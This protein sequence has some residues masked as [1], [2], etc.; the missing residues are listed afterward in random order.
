[1]GILD[2]YITLIRVDTRVTVSGLNDINQSLDTLIQTLKKLELQSNDT[3]ESLSDK[4]KSY[5]DVA[6][7][8]M[9]FVLEHS[10]MMQEK[11][12]AAHSLGIDIGQYDALSRAF[13]AAGS[14]AKSF[15]ASMMALKESLKETQE[16]GQSGKADAFKAFGVSPTD[17]K[18][19]TK[20]ADQMMVELAGAAAKMDPLQA[21]AGLKQLGISDDAT[22]A[23]LMKG[24]AE[25]ERQIALQKS[26]GVMSLQDADTLN[27]F[28][29]AQ[30]DL[31]AILTRFSDELVIGITPAMTVL[32]DTTIEL[33]AWGREHE[34]FLLGFFGTLAAVAVPTLLSMAA[35]AAVA[36]VPFLPLI[37]A[38]TLLGLA[39]DDLWT[40]FNGGDSVIGDLVQQ[41]PLLGIALDEAKN[42][43]AEAWEALK[44][45]FSDPGAFLALL[46]AEFQA[47][48]NAIVANVT[49]AAGQLSQAFLLAWGQMVADAQTMFNVLWEFI[50]GLFSHLGD[51]IVG[52]VRN[53]INE[54]TGLLP[55]F[56]K[57]RLG[58]EVDDEPPTP[59]NADGG[60]FGFHPFWKNDSLTATAHNVMSDV[61]A[62]PTIPPP[63]TFA[64][65]TTSMRS[66]NVNRVDIHTQA[67]DSQGIGKSFVE[68]L[69][70]AY[71]DLAN[72][73]DDG[74]GY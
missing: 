32:I 37:G 2:T 1:M 8:V 35:A 54:V 74:R 72:H 31:T 17:S 60:L 64:A 29:R 53:A 10:E 25:L 58:L 14:D 67:T 18:G 66:V 9:N 40:Y 30:G 63:S 70:N 49:E 34:S 11:V 52:L 23:A 21:S 27:Q 50:K 56:I 28:A 7:D 39:I 68:G 61:A 59:D 24:S 6:Q 4:L 47:S 48:W 15:N 36:I 69:K 73:Y 57:T 20:N 46:V 12:R 45:L 42:S 55:D 62:I 71:S 3:G 51:N 5:K 33:M 22:I 44:L 38:A 16:Q 65:S 41:F 43:V 26:F 19:K 13:Q